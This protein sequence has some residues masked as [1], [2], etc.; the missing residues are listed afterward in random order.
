MT[1]SERCAKHQFERASGLCGQCGYPYCTDCL[2]TPFPKKPPICKSCA[3]ALA[4]VRNRAAVRP[5]RNAKEIKA[6]MKEQARA[7]QAAEAT[8]E[9]RPSRMGRRGREKDPAVNPVAFVTDADVVPPTL[10][11]TK[12]PARTKR[13]WRAAG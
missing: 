11:G 2:I 9:A 7:A 13:L 8:H 5:A 3:M 6:I 1:E 10:A 4:G 12:I